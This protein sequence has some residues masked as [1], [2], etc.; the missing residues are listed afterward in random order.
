MDYEL[1]R[2][3]YNIDSFVGYNEDE[4]REMCKG[5]DLIPAALLE[6]E[7]ALRKMGDLLGDI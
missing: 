4:I 2:R 3:L 5:F 7:D 1:L 6:S